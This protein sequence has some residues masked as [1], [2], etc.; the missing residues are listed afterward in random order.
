MEG[1]AR[2]VR[3]ARLEQGLREALG[4]LER[5]RQ[6]LLA[7]LEELVGQV[8]LLRE[9]QGRRALRA[10]YT[11]KAFLRSFDKSQEGR[12]LAAQHLA[13]AARKQA[14]DRA[15]DLA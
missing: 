11:C 5:E 3:G 9:G 15:S 12:A 2:Q 6:G 14:Y 10:E 4:P 7:G 8:V 13:L 1:A